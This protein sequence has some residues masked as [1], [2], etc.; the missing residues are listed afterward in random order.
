MFDINYFKDIDTMTVILI[1]I[2]VAI[3]IY[4]VKQSTNYSSSLIEGI[5][6]RQA[7]VKKSWQG[8]PNT[9]SNGVKMWE[10]SSIK[11]T[12]DD[13]K[14]LKKLSETMLNELDLNKNKTD[15]EDILIDLETVSNTFSTIIALDMSKMLTEQTKVKNTTSEQA[16]G[17]SLENFMLSAFQ[18]NTLQDF[19]KNINNLHAWTQSNSSSA[20]YNKDK[21]KTNKKMGSMF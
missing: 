11:Y 18:L 4:F 10:K 2:G 5:T 8:Q 13:L 21:E 15:Y 3:I 16:A 20:A 17:E 6:N 19:V 1:V 12:D 14:N 9:F 7:A